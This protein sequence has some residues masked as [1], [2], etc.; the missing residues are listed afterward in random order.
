MKL[1]SGRSMT[2]AEATHAYSPDEA[3]RLYQRALEDRSSIEGL[4]ELRSG[5]TSSFDFDAVEQ[6]KNGE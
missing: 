3:V 5:L 2:E 1:V 4:A 6:L